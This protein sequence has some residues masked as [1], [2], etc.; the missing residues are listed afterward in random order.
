MFRQLYIAIVSYVSL[1]LASGLYYREFTKLNDFT[2]ATQLS[3]VHTH[4]LALGMLFFLVMLALER[5]FELSQYKSFRVFFITYNL[6]L[7]LTTVMM[8]V[9]G[10]MQVL[11]SASADSPALAGM[12]GL[13]HITITV[14]LVSLLIALKQVCIPKRPAAP[15]NA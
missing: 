15:A 1:G 7:V 8:T 9:K 6:G 11:G 13:G 10:S 12:A 14:A 5:L 2:G 4:F 3:T